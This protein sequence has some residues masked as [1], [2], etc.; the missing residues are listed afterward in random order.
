MKLTS[1]IATI[2]STAMVCFLVAGCGGGGD[3]G[4]GSPTTF[5]VQPST[6]SVTS[7]STTACFSGFVGTIFV[8]GGTAPYRLDNTAPDSVTLSTNTVADRGGSFDVTYTGAGCFD[9][10]LI[11]VVDK[12]DHVVTLSL[13]SKLKT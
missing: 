3:D 2:P 9:P 12:L 10:A 7:P 6:L 11:V 13:T 5:S 4:A 8:Y 1:L